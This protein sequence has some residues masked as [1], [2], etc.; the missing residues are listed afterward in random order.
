[1]NDATYRLLARLFEAFLW[2]GELVGEENLPER[3]PAVFVANHLGAMGPI[4]V[5]AS[6]PVRVYPWVIGDMLDEEKAPAYL[7]KDFVEPQ[8][9]I[10]PP[11]SRWLGLAISK[12]SVGLLRSAGCIAVQ[13]G[14]QL[15]DTYHRSVDL[16]LEGKNLLIF[17]E[18]PHQ[19][20]DLRVRMT[21]FYKGFAR[22]GEFYYQR[23]GR[24]L[25]FVP[26][27]VHLETYRVRVGQKVVF[28]PTLN[29]VHERLRIKHVL[30][31]AIREMY[32]DMASNGFAR[33]P[34]TR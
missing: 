23:S 2:G 31:A 28:N 27:A 4:A 5:L 8:L 34:S 18:D 26:L 16:L 10:P 11:A 3:G 17:P 1:M 29:P 13:Q 19:E 22:L 25:T 21:P 32:L 20:F 12:I 30:E 7:V 9:H 6:L 33:L 14:E 24:A 15:L